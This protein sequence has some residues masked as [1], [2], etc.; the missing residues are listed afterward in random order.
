MDIT[1][2]NQPCTGVTVREVAVPD[3][4]VP[5][6]VARVS[7]AVRSLFALDNFA[8]D[9]TGFN[10]RIRPRGVLLTPTLGFSESSA[11]LARSYADHAEALCLVKCTN[12]LLGLPECHAVLEFAQFGLSVRFFGFTRPGNET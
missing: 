5:P 12:L 4:V 3:V 8:I 2:S 11:D 1:T 6:C 10:K 7:A 9:F